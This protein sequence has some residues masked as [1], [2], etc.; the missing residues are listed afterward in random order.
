MQECE[1]IDNSGGQRQQITLPMG[2]GNPTKGKKYDG[3]LKY[4]LTQKLCIGPPTGKLS[5]EEAVAVKSDTCNT[6]YTVKYLSDSPEPPSGGACG[7]ACPGGSDS[8]CAWVG[9]ANSCTKCDT[10]PGTRFTCVAP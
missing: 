4:V 9:G 5:K 8:E 1:W 3:N 2:G 10:T 7:K 6:E